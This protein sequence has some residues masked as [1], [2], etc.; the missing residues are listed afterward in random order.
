MDRL[1]FWLLFMLSL[2]STH[3]ALGTD[4]LLEPGAA[5]DVGVSTVVLEQATALVRQSVDAQDIHGAVVLVAKQGKIIL[6]E[7][8]G[9]RDVDARLP[10]QPDTL[11][12]MASNTK[13]VVAAAIL[14]LVDEGRLELDA[15][16]GSYLPSWNHGL[17]ADMT[18]RHLLCHTSGL[19][20]PVIFFNPL[21]EKSD[22]HP[23]RPSLAAEVD[24][25][26]STG[27]TEKPG[28]SYSYSN[29]GY[30]VLGRLIEM[31][32]GQSLKDYLRSEI[33]EPL[34]MNH[35]WN[36]ESDAPADRMGCVYPWK[37]G[38][39]VCRWKP[40]D[41][42][43]WP[44]VRG[45]GGM[46]S[47]VRDYASFCQMFLN[48]GRYHGRRILTS[49]RVRE[50]TAPQTLASHS[51]TELGT[52]AA[53][54]G[55]G[56]SI[57]RR[58]IFSH[59]G[60]D[61]TIAWVDPDRELIVLMFTQCPGGENPREAFFET[62]LAACDKRPETSDAEPRPYLRDLGLTI[63]VLPTGTTNSLTDVAGVRVGHQ[64]IVQG[65]SI[66]TGVT[67][68]WPHPGNTFLRKVP[69]AIHVA[70]GFG[71]FIGSTQVEELG[72]LETPII[73]TNTLSA[74]AAADAL[75]AW[76]LQQP[77]CEAVRSVNP[78]VG[79]CNDGGLNDI[80]QQ[81]VGRDDVLRALRGAHSGP[82]T[83]GCV[84]AGTG[85]TCMGW[86]GG[87]GSSSRRLP[88]SLG[89]YTVGVLV[90][91]NFGGSLTVAGI[92]VGQQLG[93]YY[94]KNEVRAQ[95]HGSCVVV[96]A[97]DA[98]LDSRRLG[99]LA[100]RAPLGLATAGSSISHGSGD[101]V[102]AFSTASELQIPYESPETSETTKLLR[103]E[104]LSPLFQA[105]RDA[106]EEAV[107]NSMLQAV[108]T[109]GHRGQAVQA[110]D[111]QSLKDLI[112]D[113]RHKVT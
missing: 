104:H 15:K 3:L 17:T 24:R 23:D 109:T 10:M 81:R 62:V 33:Y 16:V 96:V 110:I 54:Y 74:F 46:I 13:P 43:D 56:W 20:I 30:Q 21:L 76:S 12:K 102:I 80:R 68:I 14:K 99:R 28:S 82:V 90:Q 22:E 38:R 36:H 86:K 48:G 93:R 78:V 9:W 70:N 52:Q 87:I 4:R 66:R 67:A 55:L 71:K 8:I 103:D 2:S 72:N 26:A 85:I 41:G 60:S 44:F 84:G 34:E 57:D 97:T 98:P 79:E 58:G 42:V 47:T 37:D 75:T 64:T 1:N 49:D 35:S 88:D 106:T 45:S 69:A 101:Y 100:R 95:E 50:A 83:Q 32:S 111:V 73:L 108:T 39:R 25:F 31:A 59:S 18:V 11:F 112:R 61:G 27:V 5:K 6:H 63:G 51:A 77:G 113:S 92:P 105:V 19:R 91:T 65:D 40:E 53:F 7:A 107:I 89:G 94:L 29:P